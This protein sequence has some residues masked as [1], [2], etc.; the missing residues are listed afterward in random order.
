MSMQRTFL[1]LAAMTMAAGA[2][3]GDARF[4]I[5]LIGWF[6]H[7]YGAFPVRRRVGPATRERLSRK[8]MP[9]WYQNECGVVT[10]EWDGSGCTARN[11][12]QPGALRLA[13]VQ[14]R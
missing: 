3:A 10:L 4:E 7:L 13:S 14:G 1:L 12:A 2:A 11:R 5:P 9:V 6:F 8:P